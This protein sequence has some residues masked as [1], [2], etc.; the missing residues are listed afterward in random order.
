MVGL[1]SAW[2]YISAFMLVFVVVISGGTPSGTEAGVPIS[3]S[4]ESTGNIV[5]TQIS[6]SSL[7]LSV[8]IESWNFQEFNAQTIASSFEMSQSAW[9]PSSDSWSQ[10][11][12]KVDQVHGLNSNYKFLMYR[13][14][15]SIYN[16][17]PDEWNYAKSQGWLLKDTNGNYVTESGLSSNYMVDITNASYQLWLGNKV[18]SWL[19]QHPSFDGVMADN[20]LKYSAQE[21]DW[22]AIARPINP[23]TGTYFTDRQILDGC[24]GVINAIIDKIGT[25][26]ILA[27]NGVWNGAIWSNAWP[28]GDNYRYI[29]S[30][31]PRLN[32]IVSEGTF[33]PGGNQWYSVSEWKNSIDFVAWV[34]DNFLNG[35]LDRYFSGTCKTG[36]LP[37]GSTKDQVIIYGYCSM[38]LATK[39]SSPQNTIDFSTD[40]SQNPSLLQLI[41]KLQAVEMGSPLGSYYKI[42]S[43]SVYARD[44]SGGKILVNPSEN[45]YTV[46]LNTN[47]KT[48]S[49]E[50]VSGSLTVYPHTGVVLI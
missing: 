47:Y 12:T 27:P 43:T 37:T 48:I 14:C 21:F 20:G 39:Y 16:Y 2:K 18:R 38:L 33:M 4:I 10:Y 22:A 15:M 50:T 31:V 3:R 42:G 45:P 25:Q 11:D 32:C 5:Y 24:A 34:Q 36:S 8:Y 1:G 7:K 26:K 6:N 29:L 30:K 9:I 40:F 44:F 41:Q 49:G 13:N 19:I 35:H 28:G 17:W 23:N 46:L